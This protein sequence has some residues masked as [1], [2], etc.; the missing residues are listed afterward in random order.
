MNI[1]KE[2]L[3]NSKWLI[4]FA[5]F[6]SVCSA[7]ASIMVISMINEMISSPD[8]SQSMAIKGIGFFLLLFVTG[9]ISQIL[10][11]KVGHG[12]VYKIRMIMVKRILD[13]DLEQL[14]NI[15][16]HSLYASLTKDIAQIGSAFNSIPFIIYNLVLLLGGFT[17]MAY[18][19]WP[20]FIATLSIIVI[21]VMTSTILMEKMRALMT[22]VRGIDDE[23]FAGYQGVIEGNSEMQL[24]A[25]RKR[26][27]YEEEIEPVVAKS[28]DTEIKADTY[29]VL[30][31][32]WAV[33]TL[34]GLVFSLFFVGAWFDIGS[35]VVAGYILV[36][37]FLRSPI[38]DLM[39]DYPDLIKAK[40]SLNKI[41]SMKLPSYREAFSESESTANRCIVNPILQL[42]N[43][44]YEYKNE[45][46][47][48]TFHL[49]PVNF[50]LENGEIVFIIGGNGSGKSTLAK[51]ISGLYQAHGGSISLSG[52]EINSN[53]LDWYRSHFSTVFSSFYLFKRLVGPEGKLD[54]VLAEEFLKILKMDKKITLDEEKISNTQLSQGQR[55]RLALL[56]ARVEERPIWLLDEWAADQDP[57]FRSYFYL[58]LLPV[59]KSKGISVI[60]ISHDDQYF[61]MADKIYKCDTGQ[62]A[63]LDHK[64]AKRE[65]LKNRREISS[66]VSA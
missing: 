57:E 12:G 49:G 50:V 16:G 64:S 35:E 66:C 2:L 11:I 39:S 36:L 48:Y 25:V 29:W 51:V 56:L 24:N 23:I 44:H 42:N 20:L 21:S 22:V 62:L 9:V 61:H 10:L 46:N 59:V 19:S 1:I 13:L 58:E 26:L 14:E 33:V 47:D 40:I 41:D 6:A 63:L 53:N 7:L 30:N 37:M 54:S 32:N 17:Y 60:A 5:I 8:V 3:K 52:Q 34:L 18:L 55:K 38:I 27:F 28:R 43:V 45:D 15:G 4:A 31:K 65:V